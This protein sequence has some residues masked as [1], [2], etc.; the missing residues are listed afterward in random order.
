[1]CVFTRQ[2]IWIVLSSNYWTNVTPRVQVFDYRPVQ[3]NVRNQHA[4][5]LV[6][7]PNTIDLLTL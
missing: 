3:F 2:G 7:R 6:A 4:A 1:M 5:R